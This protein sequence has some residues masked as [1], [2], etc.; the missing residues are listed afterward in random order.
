MKG[1]SI[2]TQLHGNFACHF[3][4]TKHKTALQDLALGFRSWPAHIQGNSQMRAFCVQRVCTAP[5]SGSS[6]SWLL[7][8]LH[9]SDVFF[10]SMV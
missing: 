1:E 8:R 9:S 6:V 10:A 5:L 2:E 4:Q 7:L 3:T